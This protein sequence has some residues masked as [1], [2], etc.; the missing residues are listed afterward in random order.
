MANVILASDLN[1]NFLDAIQVCSEFLLGLRKTSE[2]GVAAACKFLTDL[3][4][5]LPKRPLM[6]DEIDKIRTLITANEKYR[7]DPSTATT[8]SLKAFSK[9]VDEL[10]SDATE[11]FFAD[12]LGAE[13]RADSNMGSS[14]DVVIAIA[15]ASKLD[16]IT[17]VL[18]STNATADAA[19]G[20]VAAA[21]YN[22]VTP[23]AATNY[24]QTQDQLDGNDKGSTEFDVVGDTVFSDYVQ[25]PQPES[26]YEAIAQ[27]AASPP[28]E[29]G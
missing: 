3:G 24:E 16:A 14:T 20:P 8:K 18:A 1:Q 15:Q 17:A 29:E 12:E 7:I 11:R 13:L 9:L 21:L 26:Y 28:G 6:T 23:D 4:L 19:L 10:N 22:T 25:P 27:E 5:N 2:W